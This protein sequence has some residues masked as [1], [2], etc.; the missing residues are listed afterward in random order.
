MRITEL[1]EIENDGTGYQE[2]CS[3]SEACG[4]TKRGLTRSDCIYVISKV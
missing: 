3:D 4:L 1:L 2:L